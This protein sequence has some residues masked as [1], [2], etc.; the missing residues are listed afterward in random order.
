[1]PTDR[2][3]GS[4][5]VIAATERSCGAAICEGV[6]PSRADATAVKRAPE[7]PNTGTSG[8]TKNLQNTELGHHCWRDVTGRRMIPTPG[9]VARVSRSASD[10]AAV[11]RP[12]LWTWGSSPR[13]ISSSYANRRIAI[14]R[15]PTATGAPFQASRPNRANRF[16]EPS[17]A[18][19]LQRDERPPVSRFHERQ[20]D[21]P[22]KAP[23]RFRS[24]GTDHA[25]RRYSSSSTGTTWPRPRH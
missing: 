17:N 4:A 1:M 2:L 23:V 25:T 7:T 3:H 16:G 12:F 13:P 19:S 9:T 21:R 22:R 11:F 5:G 8:T 20:L 14:T 15:L 6:K 24:A 10:G 18:Q